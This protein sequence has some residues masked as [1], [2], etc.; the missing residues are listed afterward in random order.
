MSL[1]PSKFLFKDEVEKSGVEFSDP[2]RR[3]C[4]IHG[5]LSSSQNDV[6]VQ[7]ADVGAVDQQLAVP[8]AGRRVLAGRDEHRLGLVVSHVRYRLG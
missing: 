2:R 8:Q 3:R 5:V 6:V 7:R 1:Y 4:D